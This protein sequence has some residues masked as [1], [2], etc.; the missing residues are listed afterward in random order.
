MR[1]SVATSTTDEDPK[2]EEVTNLAFRGKQLQKGSKLADL[3]LSQE[4]IHYADC[5]AYSQ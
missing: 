1:Q 4:N 3:T 2:Y 5:S